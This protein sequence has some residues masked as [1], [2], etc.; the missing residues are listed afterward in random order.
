MV[1]FL[2][3]EYKKKQ[4]LQFFC[5]SFSIFEDIRF[6]GKSI[7][8]FRLP[9]IFP[10]A[11]R[12]ED[13]KLGLVCRFDERK[14]KFLAD[15]KR[16]K[17]PETRD[18]IFDLW[19]YPIPEAYLKFYPSGLFVEEREVLIDDL[20][21]PIIEIKKAEANNKEYKT[22]SEMVLDGWAFHSAANRDDLIQ[23]WSIRP[24]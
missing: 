17:M 21:S 18:C 16:C 22:L 1:I 11:E 23:N 13:F 15:L 24:F 10:N 6:R 9:I 7:V 2:S 12:A 14:E 8:E 3:P 5:L 4:Y 20:D 19:Y